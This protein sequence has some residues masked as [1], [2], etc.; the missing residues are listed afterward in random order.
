M[1]RTPGTPSA[2]VVDGVLFDLDDTL[3]D[4][5]G[6]QLPAFAETVR[7]QWPDAPPAEAGVFVRAAD[8][9]AA[10]RSGHYQRYIAGELDFAG[11]RLARARDALAVLGAP[12]AVA[13]PDPALWTDEYE[14]RVRAHWAL[15][16]DVVPTLATLRSSGVALGIV[17]N[18]VEAYQ[19]AK[20]DAL[21]L[22]AIT[23]LVG[24]DSAG[25]P[26]PDPAPFLEACR[27]MGTT[28]GRTAC[29]GDSLSHDVRGARAAG[30]VP[31]WLRRGAGAADG[32]GEGRWD[33]AE[34]A[35]TIGGLGALAAWFPGSGADLA[36]GREVL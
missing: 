13:E 14:V 7:A 34:G 9:F 28:P 4:L 19:R 24:S 8:H 33:A 25:A 26:K 10:D 35:W 12:G 29:V 6:A 27:R 21:G 31:V 3:L 17:T 23:V 2:P 5:R 20:A 30:L 32:G 16:D 18:N 1:I 11:Q 22:E 36:S 15:F